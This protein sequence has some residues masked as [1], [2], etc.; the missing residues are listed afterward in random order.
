MQKALVQ[1]ALQLPLVVSDITGMTG[2]RIL[3]DLVAGLRDPVQL[4]AHRDH[5]C[6]A[7]KTEI[8]AALTGPS[9]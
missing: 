5:R 8:I 1:M 4:A 9:R 6:R 7:S 3:R 2:L